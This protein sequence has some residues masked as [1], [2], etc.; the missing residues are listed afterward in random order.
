[1]KI[2]AYTILAYCHAIGD[3]ITLIKILWSIWLTFASKS[4][5]NVLE[6][7]PFLY[8]PAIMQTPRLRANT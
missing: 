2:D 5:I 4:L 8:L 7:E 1:M 3:R 6:K